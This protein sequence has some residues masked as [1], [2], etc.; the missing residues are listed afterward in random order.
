MDKIKL[1]KDNTI[2]DI[3]SDGIE[4]YYVVNNPWK[5]TFHYVRWIDHTVY[6]IEL[7]RE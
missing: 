5:Y 6:G 4:H 2:W 3:V 7:K 1:Y